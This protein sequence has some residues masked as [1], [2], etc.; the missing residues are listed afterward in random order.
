MRYTSIVVT[1]HEKHQWNMAPIRY[2]GA[3]VFGVNVLPGHATSYEITSK[4]RYLQDRPEMRCNP[5]NLE[6]MDECLML[7]FDKNMN[8][9]LPWR[10][11]NDWN[12]GENKFLGALNSN[13]QLM[14][15][16]NT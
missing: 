11:E 7:Y 12:Q 15:V 6:K 16:I 13:S 8:C 5:A 3:S 2:L 14:Q 1:L 9:K 10:D 4:I